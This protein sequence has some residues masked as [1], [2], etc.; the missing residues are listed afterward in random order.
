MIFYDKNYQN[1]K[2]KNASISE[3]I[4]KDGTKQFYLSL[5]YI[6]QDNKK[7]IHKLDIPKINLLLENPSLDLSLFNYPKIDFGDMNFVIEKNEKGEILTDKIIK[8][9]CEEMTIEEIQ[10]KLGYKIKIV[11]KKEKKN[12]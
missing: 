6:Y 12:D 4:N 10:E 1:I 5:T 2:L 8:Y 9:H 7:N 3:N 11:D